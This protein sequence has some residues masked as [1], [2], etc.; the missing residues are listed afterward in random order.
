MFFSWFFHVLFHVVLHVYF[1]VFSMFFPWFSMFFSVPDF[2]FTGL[3]F[4][5]ILTGNGTLM[6]KLKFRKMKAERLP[7]FE[8]VKNSWYVTWR[9]DFDRG[10]AYGQANVWRYRFPC[11]FSWW[12]PSMVLISRAGMRPNASWHSF[13]GALACI[14]R[15]VFIHYFPDASVDERFFR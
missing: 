4:K 3:Q 7:C 11:Q 15:R 6:I 1:H 13:C 5:E 8:N 10:D 14:I 9:R 12:R 2:E